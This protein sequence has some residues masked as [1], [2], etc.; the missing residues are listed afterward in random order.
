MKLKSLGGYIAVA[1]TCLAVGNITGFLAGVW[2]TKAGRAF[3]TNLL[4]SEKPA[5]VTQSQR[6][7]RDSFEL[8]Y[9]GNW[10][11]DTEDDD[12][13]PDHSFSIDSPGACFVMFHLTDLPV[14][15][16]RNVE[17]HAE[18]FSKLISASEKL[19]FQRWGQYDGE[20]LHLKGRIMGMKGGFR[21]FAHSS[22]GRSFSVVQQY[23][24]EDWASV[25]PGFDLIEKTFELRKEQEQKAEHP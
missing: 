10:R 20:G 21:F 8:D 23:F 7:V 1:L 2:S 6:L 14:E 19:P 3:L 11:I 13:D 22:N 18:K 4:S 15:P 5:D 17:I 16:A 12:Y 25:G 9:P 24:D